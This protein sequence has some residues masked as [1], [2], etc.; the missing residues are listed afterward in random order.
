ME[1]TDTPAT[2]MNDRLQTNEGL[3][4]FLRY[5]F[6]SFGMSCE[7]VVRRARGEDHTR[8]TCV[9]V[10]TDPEVVRNEELQPFW[11][12][13]AKMRAEIEAIMPVNLQIT[14]ITIVQ[15]KSIHVRQAIR[16]FE[17]N[18]NGTMYVPRWCVRM[19]LTE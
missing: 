9:L 5:I 16:F 12:N 4:N 14:A 18:I 6:Y 17:T 7:P 13:V 19:I 11:T 8:C 10:V 1:S 2:A 15:I 3:T